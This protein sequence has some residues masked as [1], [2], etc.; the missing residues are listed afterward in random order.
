MYMIKKASEISGVSVRT[1]HHYDEIGLLSPKKSG[2]GYRYYS[3]DDM[4]YLQTILFYKHLGF[5]LK[6]IKS[7]LAKNEIELI[8]HLKRQLILMQNK[9]EK[10][11]TLI[12][13][14][15]KTIDY[16]ERKITM[17]TRERFKGF[18]YQDSK[19]YEQLAIDKYGKDMIEEARERHEGKEEE[20]TEK[21]NSILT[22][23][24]VNMEKGLKP[25]SKDNIELAK[26]LHKFICEYYFDC[27]IDAFSGI[28]YGYT[29]NPEF[30]TNID[31]FGS[32]TAEYV[33]KA[34]QEYVS[35]SQNKQ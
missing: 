12:N 26:T 7:L 5:S 8:T 1:L 6:Q 19:K 11:L 33:C 29:E 32:G 3:E 14:L 17:S 23:F 34:I 13:T 9:K 27:S 31:R 4:A 10:L 15:Q 20:S 28:G 30:K 21:L 25:S 24:V 18:T 22:A 35:K 2:N 16:E